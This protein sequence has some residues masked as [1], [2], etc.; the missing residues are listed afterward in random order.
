[1]TATQRAALLGL[2]AVVLAG[3]FALLRSTDAAPP[4]PAAT[5]T[6][7]ATTGNATTTTTGE[8]RP[9]AGPLLSAG[10]IRTIEI[11]K[12]EEVRFRVRSAKA[13]EL[14]VHGYDIARD[15]PPGRTVRVRFDASLDGVFEIELER[16]GTPIGRLKV[17]P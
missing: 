2:T 14:H 8:P 11:R 1:M 15:L 10:E 9:D 13:E 16:S 5:A 7:A 4:R 17:A 3:A 12:G 6:T